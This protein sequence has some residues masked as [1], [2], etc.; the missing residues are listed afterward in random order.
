MVGMEEINWFLGTIWL[1]LPAYFAN[2]AP[3]LLH[4]GGSL[5]S[6]RNWSDGKRILGDHKTLYGTIIGIVVG[7]LFGIIQGNL[8]QGI[9]FSVGAILGDLLFAFIKRRLGI[10]P[11]KSLPLWDQVGFIIVA[12]LLGSLVEPRPT[13]QQDVAMIFTTIPVHYVSNLF[14]WGLSWKKEPW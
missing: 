3:V 10:Q 13:W 8:L 2:A 9:L 4:G 5:D 1:F 7:S 6:G 12:I 11:G 14:A